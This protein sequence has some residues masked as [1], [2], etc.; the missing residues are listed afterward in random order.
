M[1]SYSSE[2]HID[3]LKSNSLFEISIDQKKQLVNIEVY[4]PKKEHQKE[5]LKKL[6][7]QFAQRA[8]ALGLF[9]PKSVNSVAK[10]VYY[11]ELAERIILISRLY[12]K[13]PIQINMT[14]AEVTLE[15]KE[16]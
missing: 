13:M 9:A 3:K 4:G 12:I 2:F 10:N 15:V 6:K 14:R 5:D 1:G 11:A 8:K 16:E 7:A